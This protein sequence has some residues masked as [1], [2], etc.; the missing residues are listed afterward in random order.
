VKKILIFFIAFLSIFVS[1][2]AQT[3]TD[4]SIAVDDGQTLVISGKIIDNVS[5]TALEYANVLLLSLPDSIF[6]S[7]TVSNESGQFHFTSV[8][9]GK[10]VLKVSYIGF[11]TDIVPCE[12]STNSVDM[13][14]IR[15]KKSNVLE[16][17]VVTAGKRP[18]QQGNNGG[19]VANVAT[20][21][22]SSVGTVNDVLQRMPGI[23]V[24]N[25]KITVFGK[26]T[27]IVYINNRK[28]QDVSE[29]ERLESSEISTVELITNPGA[30][31]D[32]EG[33]TVL[34]IKTKGKRDGFSARITERIRQGKYLR[35]N[36]NISILYTYNKLNMFATYFRDSNKGEQQEDHYFELKNSDGA[37]QHRILMPVIN[38][39]FNSQ[40]I[41]SG[42]DFSINEKHAVGGQYQFYTNKSNL[43]FPIYTSSLLNGLKYDTAFSQS[44]SQDNLRQHLV[45][46]FYDGNFNKRYSLRF[47]FDFLKNHN[48]RNQHTDE[49]VNAVQ[50]NTVNIFNQ[51]DY[52]LYAG[53]LTNSYK[54][55][56][57]M[58]EF[59][60]EYNHIAGSGFVQSNE[61]TDNSE[62]TNT[63][64]KTAGFA[65]YSHKIAKINM[66]AGLRYEFTSEQ[67]TQGEAKTKIIDHTY[68]D[69]YP[70]ISFS[71]TIKGLDLSL[72]FNKRTQ[73]PNFSQLNG[74][75]IYVNRFLFQK[76][77][78]YLNKANIYDVN[79]Q[80]TINPFYLN[81]GYSYTKN[82]V[83]MYFNEQKNNAILSTYA[84]FPK[85][86]EL[87][88]TLNFNHKIIFW[89]PNYTAGLN[90]P[91]FSAMYDGQKIEYNKVY[92]FFR[93]YND[94]TLPS[95]FVLSCNF[96]Y[97]SD[98]Q[99]AFVES[100]GY[101]RLDAGIRKSFFNN[102]LRL[103]L[104]VYDIF[105]WVNDKN[106]VKINNLYWNTG[107]KRETRYTTLSVTYI[108]N[109]YN[110][111]YRGSSA[112]QDDI[113]RF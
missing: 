47:D 57:G 28:V 88:T 41:S 37:W 58:I 106:S 18:F 68:S 11:E 20:T 32:A 66:T 5:E 80:A 85:M 7:G 87:N 52:D 90:K 30:K 1:T 89:Q 94:F 31:Y 93:L 50:I 16:G 17:A 74:N 46:I 76:G 100:N 14:E 78:P 40:Q 60:M 67:F 56:A 111:K 97:Q 71:T 45:N 35:D 53:K 2:S 23:T 8:G 25:G 105:D 83:L 113:D 4:Y 12:I 96:L 108:F 33:R 91:F 79:L 24:D 22:L 81:I 38:Y 36:E 55:N 9:S 65:S 72:A 39:S 92:Y 19:I 43:D 62:F 103:N 13:N 98:L 64:Q 21:L 29:L 6:I 10:Y 107:R 63:E 27:P 112:A 48:Y 49:T 101:R 109:N 110:R 95:G 34:L 61:Y 84:N 54:L 70:N 73:R 77:D 99:D 42:F 26:G 69:L 102:V 59:G 51:T 82:P 15:L 75:V 3:K 86:Q 104:M 44:V